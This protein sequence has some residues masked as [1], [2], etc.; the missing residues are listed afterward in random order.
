M[1]Q[2]KKILSTFSQKFHEVQR[3]METHSKNQSIFEFPLLFW[4][5]R[6]FLADSSHTEPPVY[7]I[8][9]CV[10]SLLVSNNSVWTAA[11]SQLNIWSRLKDNDDN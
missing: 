8:L 11:P 1:N 7:S 3:L 9:F 6:H 10:V 5:S 2:K 4:I